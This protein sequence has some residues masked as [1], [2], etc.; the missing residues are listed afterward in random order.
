[1]LAIVIT[2]LMLFTSV[3]VALAQEPDPLKVMEAYDLAL[4]EGNV[5]GALALFADDAVLTTQQGQL[6]GKEQ[7]WTWLERVVAQNSRVEPVNR[8]VNGAKV[9]WQSNFFRK[10]IA[11]LSN[12]PL[13]ANAEAVVEVG[14][15]KS[16]SSILTDEAQ[17]KLAAAQPAPET[18]AAAPAQNTAAPAQDAA[19]QNAAVP[20]QLPQT[21]GTSPSALPFSGIL[22]ITG[23]LLLGMGLLVRRLAQIA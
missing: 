4:N 18:T 21:G 12:E 6:V 2:A 22:V 7:I 1:M 17:A 23:G 10:D 16:F 13:A 5:D 15:I 19:A 20:P 9:T 11:T 3:G 8:Q 14:K